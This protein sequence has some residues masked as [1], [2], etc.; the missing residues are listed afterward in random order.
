MKGGLS[1]RSVPLEDVAAFRR[2]AD[3]WADL[4]P[5]GGAAA[6]AGEAI[7]GDPSLGDPCYERGAEACFTGF[8]TSSPRHRQFALA[9]TEKPSGRTPSASRPVAVGR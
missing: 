5:A 9:A 6:A 1:L 2:A 4:A 7:M 8:R 3:G